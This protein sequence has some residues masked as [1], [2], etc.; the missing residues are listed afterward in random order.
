MLAA[1]AALVILFLTAWRW[2]APAPRDPLVEAAALVAASDP[3]AWSRAKSIVAPLSSSLDKDDPRRAA[4]S[5]L[6][7]EAQS[8]L[9]MYYAERGETTSLHTPAERQFIAAWQAEQ[10][11]DFQRAASAY[12]SAEQLARRSEADHYVEP[13]AATRRVEMERLLALPRD[14][15]TLAHWIQEWRNQAAASGNVAESVAELQRVLRRFANDPEML[16][17]RQL[18]RQA[19]VELTADEV[20]K[21]E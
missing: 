17:L 10:E 14:A 4:A 13:L 6:R 8:K 3:N 9:I 2:L 1:S 11:R 20:G 15:E 5:S 12:R 7:D 16:E 19:I 18:A 21:Q